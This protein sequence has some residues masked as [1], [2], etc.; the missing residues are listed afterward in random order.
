[1][2]GLMLWA[3]APPARS[4]GRRRGTRNGD[5]ASSTKDNMDVENGEDE[6]KK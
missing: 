3:E 4:S 2:S 5:A 6:S 1:M